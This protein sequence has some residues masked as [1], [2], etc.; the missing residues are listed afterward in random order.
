VIPGYGHAV[1]RSTDPRFLHLKEFAERN[2]KNDYIFDLA[3]ECC[4][5]IPDILRSF[6]K[7][8]NPWPNV[9]AISGTCLQHFGTFLII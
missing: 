9:D 2:I 7:I 8:K 1:L 3:K 4:A 5:T 6:Q